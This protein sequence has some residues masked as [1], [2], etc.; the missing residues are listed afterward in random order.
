MN[1]TN[2]SVTSKNIRKISGKKKTADWEP[3]KFL[4]IKVYWILQD[5]KCIMAKFF[6][7]PGEVRK[8]CLKY[9]LTGQTIPIEDD[10]N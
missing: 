9:N 4:A 10:Q 5:I 2:K 1:L 3:L 6:T 8:Q 7:K